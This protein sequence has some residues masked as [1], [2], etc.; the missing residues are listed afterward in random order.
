MHY[1]FECLGVRKK[2]GRPSHVD[3]QPEQTETFKKEFAEL[4]Q[5]YG[6]AVYF[7][8]EM[9]T[10]ALAVSASAVGLP[11]ITVLSAG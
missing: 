5:T 11:A 8:D 3:K 1:V 9:R 6:T 4:S 7:E 10:V 2:T